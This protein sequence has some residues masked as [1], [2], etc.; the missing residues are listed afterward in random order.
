[1]GQA[2]RVPQDSA[3]GRRRRAVGMGQRRNATG[4]NDDAGVDCDPAAN[5]DG[6]APVAFD[7]LEAAR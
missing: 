7:G 4:D 1:M 5:E 2:Y 3:A 6:I